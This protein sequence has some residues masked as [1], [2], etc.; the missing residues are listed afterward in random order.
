MVGIGKTMRLLEVGSHITTSWAFYA[1]N[2]VA[3]VN[4]N[5]IQAKQLK[6]HFVLFSC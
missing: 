1:S 6:M 4:S 5:S 3:K 2:N